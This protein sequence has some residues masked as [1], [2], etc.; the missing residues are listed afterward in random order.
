MSIL[1]QL[2]AR[3]IP[4]AVLRNEA[5]GIVDWFI[6]CRKSNLRR[7]IFTPTG[8]FI[9][10]QV[11]LYQINMKKDDIIAFFDSVRTG[12]YKVE[13]KGLEGTVWEQAEEGLKKHIKRVP[14]RK[15]KKL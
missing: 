1:Y 11:Q 13:Y 3:N 12:Y 14:I 15:N 7:L 2:Q 8:A 4:H 5:V 10:N 6:L 9:H